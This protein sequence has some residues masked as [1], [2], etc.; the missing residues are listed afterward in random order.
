MEFSA[1]MMKKIW[2]VV[3]IHY[4]LQ[5]IG[6]AFLYCLSYRYAFLDPDLDQV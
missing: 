1:N 5:N 6:A 3:G 4:Q 2:G